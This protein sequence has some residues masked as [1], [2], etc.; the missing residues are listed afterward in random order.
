MDLAKIKTNTALDNLVKIQIILSTN[1]YFQSGLRDFVMNFVK[2]MTSFPEKWAFRF[3]TIVDELASN[4]IEHG[5]QAGDEIKI[6]LLAHDG[7]S[8]EIIV[9]DPG[10]GE[11][12]I[13]ASEL[14]KVY[15]DRIENFSKAEFLGIRGRGLPQIV[16]SWSD[17][18]AFEDTQSGGIRVKVIKY[19]KEEDR[20][21][22]KR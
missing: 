10:H 1:G 4:A 18:V 6:T 16:H 7:Q 21:G 17:E 8:V 3:Q 12:K 22:D 14:R 11:K 2:N 19:L 9:E 15:Q 13:N 20:E 5:C